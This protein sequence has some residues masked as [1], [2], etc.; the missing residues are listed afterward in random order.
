MF[1]QDNIKHNNFRTTN[2][3]RKNRTLRISYKTLSRIVFF[4]LLFILLGSTS[5]LL[6]SWGIIN[7]VSN[8]GR[9]GRP[10]L[11]LGIWHLKDI[12]DDFWARPFIDGLVQ[13]KVISGYPND[14]FRPEQPV[15][16]AELSAML[17]AAFREKSVPHTERQFKDVPSDFW[18]A[19]AINNTTE[20][21]FWEGYPDHT[22]RPQQSISRAN[23][24]FVITK[25]LNLEA[26]SPS[27][28]LLMIYQDGNQVSDNRQKAIAAA[29][30]AG[31]VVKHR[32]P[33]FLNPNQNATRAEAAAFI[34]QTLVHTNRAENISS[35]Y[36]V[37]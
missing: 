4:F 26:E 19:S 28:E 16:R 24:L 21:G 9:G 34:Y 2:V 11:T 22:F 29:T 15:T 3:I 5:I 30:E 10:A 14:E 33:Q 13:H 31:L 17:Y 27:E 25:G 36:V 20:S 23:A 35:P 6:E 37:E 1:N 8:F 12:E 32:D 18:A 7:L